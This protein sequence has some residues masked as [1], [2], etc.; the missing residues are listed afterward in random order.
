M[1]KTY[2]IKFWQKA[3]CVFLAIVMATTLW[4]APAQ[5]AYANEGANGESGSGFAYDT[6]IGVFG[7][8]A[9]LSTRTSSSVNGSPSVQTNQAIVSVGGANSITSQKHQGSG[10]GSNTSVQIAGVINNGDAIS[11]TNSEGMFGVSKPNGHT[12]VPVEYIAVA[13]NNSGGMFY[14]VKSSDGKIVVDAY[15]V[16]GKLKQTLKGGDGTPTNIAV[17]PGFVAVY[18]SV[19]NTGSKFGG[20]INAMEVYA[21]TSS[22]LNAEPDIVMAN[23]ND[24][25][26]TAFIKTDGTVWYQS[27]EGSAKQIVGTGDKSLLANT[28]ARIEFLQANYAKVQYPNG[29]RVAYTTSTGS[30]PE[31]GE[32]FEGISSAMANRVLNPSGENAKL[33]DADMREIATLNGQQFLWEGKVIV[34]YIPINS[35]GACEFWIYSAENGKLLR[36][37]TMSSSQVKLERQ[38]SNYAVTY[39]PESGSPYYAGYYYDADLNVLSTSS[40]PSRLGGILPGGKTIQV[41]EGTNGTYKFYEVTDVN[42][43]AIKCGNYNL[44]LGYQDGIETMGAGDATPRVQHGDTDLYCAMDEYGRF[45]A[46]NSEGKVFVPFIYDNYFDLGYISADAPLNNSKYVMVHR[47]GQWF[48][49]DVADATEIAW[50]PVVTTPEKTAIENAPVK[51]TSIKK[52]KVVIRDRT[53]TGNRL[54]PTNIKVWVGGNKL[55]RNRDYRVTYNRGVHVGRYRAIIRG[56]GRYTGKYRTYY[57]IVP[58]TPKFDRFHRYHRAFRVYWHR[59]NREFNGYQIRYSRDRNFRHYVH[60]RYFNRSHRPYYTFRNL[61]AHQRYYVQVRLYKDRHGERY[62]SHW[63]RI[64]YVRTR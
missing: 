58:R 48:F 15:S 35:Q 5:P 20:N 29:K 31:P 3:L 22:G 27:A 2:S 57:H 11:T 14:G 19:A 64:R 45:G 43:N 59:Y 38:G 33:L 32:S 56:I 4:G 52:A 12:I 36:G 7:D 18:K 40:A 8:H 55:V 23:A 34:G 60:Y 16:S 44:A 1:E 50:P 21:V 28:D 30:M 53:Y 41:A 62:F 63:S 61:K 46:V 10:T 37:T 9:F 6:A 39:T 47:D 13:S 24:N 26:G 25:S 51:K 49:Y 17:F 42:G 54:R